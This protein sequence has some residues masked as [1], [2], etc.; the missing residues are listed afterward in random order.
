[1]RCKDGSIKDVLINSSVYSEGGRFIHTRC[2][3]QDVTQLEQARKQR[4]AQAEG[5][6]KTVTE[7]TARLR[8]VVGELEAFSYSISH[9]MR[10][11]LR[12]M[13]GYS[14]YLLD[15]FGDK[16]GPEAADFLNR[17]SSSA[18]RLDR[19]IQ[20]VLTYSRVVRSELHL[21]P[22]DLDRLVRETIESYPEW[23]KPKAEIR[24]EG[25]LPT[26]LGNEAFLT[27]CITNLVGNAVKFVRIGQT[28]RVKIWAETSNGCARV[29]FEDNGIGIPAKDQ[30][31]IFGMFERLHNIGVYEGT[32]IGLAIVRKAVDRMG[33]RLSVESEPGKGSKFFVELDRV[34]RTKTARPAA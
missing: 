1:M 7:R 15:Q 2:F 20:D 23:Q 30:Q 8:E 3:T 25:K 18:M 29:C 32:G 5:L 13:Q 31:R 26:V 33:G 22:V 24:V 19:L 34:D 11:P 6:E 17:I 14:K 21:V 9:D 10:A 28:P 27:Q 12:A 4:K 16:L